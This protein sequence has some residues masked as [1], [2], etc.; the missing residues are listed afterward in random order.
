MEVAYKGKGEYKSSDLQV[1]Y[2]HDGNTAKSEYIGSDD[3]F[4]RQSM[5]RDGGTA[6]G[7]FVFLVDASTVN[8][9]KG[10]FAVKGFY[11][12]DQEV[13]FAAK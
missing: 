5:P 13:Y 9:G 3:M 7:N 10:V 2:S 12:T 8:D 11:L 6:K 4:D 1:T